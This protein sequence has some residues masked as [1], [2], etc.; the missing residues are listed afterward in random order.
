MVFDTSV[1]YSDSASDLVKHEVAKLIRESTFPDLEI[2]WYLPEAVRHERQY[3]MRESAM[4][5]LPHI[6]RV[7]KLLG[8]NLA[9]NEEVLVD[10]VEKVV[11][12]RHLELGLLTPPLDYAQ[13]DWHRVTLDAVYRRPP[14]EAGDKEKGFRDRV[15]VEC[16]LQLLTASPKTASICRVVLVSDD[17]LLTKAAMARTAELTN[18]SSVSTVDELKGLI[19]TLVSRVG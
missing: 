9:I 7:E 6:R 18:V 15:I 3:Q 17:K 12:Q 2:Q 19:N 14:F 13:V 8:H 10:S 1:L 16:F 5:L 4:R 11:S